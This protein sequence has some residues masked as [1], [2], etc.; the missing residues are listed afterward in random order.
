M[1]T[2]ISTQWAC[3]PLGWDHAGWVGHYY[4]D[5]LP[6]EWRLSYFSNEFPGVALEPETWIGIP[7]T[8]VSGWVQDVP[9]GFRFYPLLPERPAVSDLQGRLN[10][11]R[12]RLGGLV[13]PHPVEDAVSHDFPIYRWGSLDE[14]LDGRVRAPSLAIGLETGGLGDLRHKRGL[15]ER[16]RLSLPPGTRVLGVLEGRPPDLDALRELEQLALL[17]GLS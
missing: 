5:D 6:V 11:F 17:L 13:A 9:E 1:S 16:L 4:P 10:L 14:A 3:V 2:R 8:V 15:L 7:D 12:G